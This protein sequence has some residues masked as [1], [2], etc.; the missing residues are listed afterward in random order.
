MTR[1]TDDVIDY[2]TWGERFYDTAVTAERILAGVN[3]LAGQPIDVGPLG[4]GPGRIAKVRARGEIGTATGHRVEDRPVTCAVTLPVSL[5]FV[6]DL[7]MDKQRF[8]AEISVPLEIIAHARADLAIALDITPP[9]PHQVVV[10]LEA[11]GLRA[12]IMQR[13]AGV[14]GELKRFVSRYV[15]REIEKPYVRAARLIDVSGAIDKAMETLGPRQAT[16]DELTE[17]LPEAL[18]TEILEAGDLFLDEEELTEIP[19]RPV[20]ERTP[21]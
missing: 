21:E 2:A 5:E 9:H 15:A 1:V 14:E 19:V 10:H 4:V 11:K 7:G 17:D 12:S 13:A 8:A 20:E 3:V 16:G 6:I 18:E